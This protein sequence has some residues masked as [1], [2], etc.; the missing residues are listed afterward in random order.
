MAHQYHECHALNVANE[1][2]ASAL[3]A[4]CRGEKGLPVDQDRGDGGKRVNWGDRQ[5]K[6]LDG[7]PRG[8]G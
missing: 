1:A 7:A 3:G 6:K 8:A 4:S 2:R 5:A